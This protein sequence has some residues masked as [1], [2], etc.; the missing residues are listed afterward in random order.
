MQKIKDPDDSNWA[1]SSNPN[2]APPWG[3][4]LSHVM[5][6]HNATQAH[7]Q[8]LC[9]TCTYCGR[10]DTRRGERERKTKEEGDFTSS[11]EIALFIRG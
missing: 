10:E 9:C 1:K 11:I 4:I 6:C 7:V 2:L 3:N 5:S 8:V